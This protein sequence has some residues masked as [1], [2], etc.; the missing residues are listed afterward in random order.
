MT[1]AVEIAAYSDYFAGKLADQKFHEGEMAMALAG[2]PPVAS[3]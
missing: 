1:D 2:R 3:G